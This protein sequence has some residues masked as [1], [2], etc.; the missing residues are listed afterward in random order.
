MCKE[1]NNNEMACNSNNKMP[2]GM[3]ALMINL[4]GNPPGSGLDSDII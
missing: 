2:T 3:V 4:N 1:V